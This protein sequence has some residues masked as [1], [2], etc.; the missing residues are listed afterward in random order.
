MLIK[1]SPPGGGG[2]S[3]LQAGS[4]SHLEGGRSLPPLVPICS[5]EELWFPRV[6]N[7]CTPIPPSTPPAALSSSHW[8]NE[9]IY[10]DSRQLECPKLHL[11]HLWSFQILRIYSLTSR[12]LLRSAICDFSELVIFWVIL[13]FQENMGSIF[14]VIWGVAL[15]PMYNL[16]VK[17]TLL[18]LPF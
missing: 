17:N 7:L 5:G 18:R 15:P 14:S 16:T 10:N 12:H 2:S 11:W 9:S 13:T 1:A 8:I 6:I 3:P 4:S